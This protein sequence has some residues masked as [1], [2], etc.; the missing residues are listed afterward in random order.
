M[1]A[2]ELDDVG[3]TERIVE[4]VVH[5][6]QAQTGDPVAKALAHHVF[7]APQHRSRHS[8]GGNEARKRLEHLT[9]E[10]FLGPVRHRNRPTRPADTKQLGRHSIRTRRE[11][12]AE[13]SGDDVKAGIAVGQR[14]GVSLVEAR[15][16][17]LGGRTAASGKDPVGGDV[18]AGDLDA[19]AGGNQ[20]ELT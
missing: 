16:E 2:K 20:P 4:P 7:I 15:V 10:T 13:D 8:R 1:L 18:H 19:S 17:T 5:A 11:H 14:L 12:R 3:R 6:R 9:D